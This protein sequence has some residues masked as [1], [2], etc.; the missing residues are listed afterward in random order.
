M[1]TERQRLIQMIPAVDVWAAF[2]A[3]GPPPRIVWTRVHAWGLY[4]VCDTQDA[5][6]DDSMWTLWQ[7][8]DTIAVALVTDSETGFLESASDTA[9]FIGLWWTEDVP[10]DDSYPA[11]EESLA[12]YVEAEERKRPRPLASAEQSKPD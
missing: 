3:I 11:I 6:E 1:I 2:A 5:Q 4:E 12:Q 10:P 9:N 7:L 8:H